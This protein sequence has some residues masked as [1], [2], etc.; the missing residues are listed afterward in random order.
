M[1]ITTRAALGTF[2]A[3]AGAWLIDAIPYALVPYLI[4]RAGGDWPLALAGFLIVGIVWTILPEAHTGG[5]L[6]KRLVGLR[7]L[8]I[9]TATPIGAKRSIVRWAV[10][11][12]ACSFLP[13]GYLWYFRNPARQTFADLAAGSV[14]VVPLPDVTEPD[15]PSVPSD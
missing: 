14:V 8:D 12:V 10:K 9:D 5:T 7:T 2:G 1:T 13:V 6:G 4:A 3:R 11:Y 15:V